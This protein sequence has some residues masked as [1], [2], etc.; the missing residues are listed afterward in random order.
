VTIPDPRPRV[1]TCAA[2]KTHKFRRKD[3]PERLRLQLL[4]ED[5]QARA[6]LSYVLDVDGKR[7]NGTSDGDGWVEEWISPA[8]KSATLELDD[9]IVDLSVGA[10]PPVSEDRGVIAR[11]AGLGFLADERE[12]EVPRRLEKALVAFQRAQALAESGKIDDATR[13]GLERAFGS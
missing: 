6:S 7:T 11:L 2:G 9:E 4:D 13:Q 8:A 12:A 5:D 3:V 1:I 10:L